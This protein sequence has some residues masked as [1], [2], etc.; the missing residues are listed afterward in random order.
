MRLGAAAALLVLGVVL[1]A[2]QGGA[3]PDL[4][5]H[6]RYL[7]RAA[8][9]EA[10]H[11]APSGQ[12]FAGGRAF[13][14]P[15]GVLY[16]PN[17]TPDATGIAGYTDDAW[18]RMLH[19]GIGRDGQHLYPAMPY[20]SY[21][22]MSRTDALAIKAYLMSLP[23]VHAV[24][25][26]DR[27]RFPFNQRW[28]MFFWNLLYNPDRRFAPD[29]SRSA[30]WN[31]GAYLVEV[32]G[33]CGE[34]HTPRN[35]AM[36]VDN[37]ERL[38]GAMEEGWLAYNLTGDRVHGLGGW[39]DAQLAQYLA[40]GYAEAHGPASGPMAEVV[41]DSLRYLT[42]GD[43]SAIV[44][45]LRSVPAQPDGPEAVVATGRSVVDPNGPG[46]RLFADACE[47]C[48]LPQGTGR[49]S[50][51]AALTGAQSA[52]DPNGTNV[53]AVLTQGSRIDT[54]FGTMF[55][56]EFAGGYTDLEL[57]ALANYVIGQFGYRQ[58][59]IT[60]Q[61]INAARKVVAVP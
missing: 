22:G 30:A 40:T 59:A 53:I 42:P 3:Q 36:A 7:T 61:R 15:F 11:S 50:P 56:H 2:A 9:C 52:G 18:V 23:P 54:A 46:A 24:L 31:H 19:Q 35:F 37:G 41:E 6:G 48:H 51:W 43:I 55:M 21:T 20:P 8:D 10:C 27:L 12:P 5:A 14:L 34:C 16:A 32:L 49:Q 17:I 1:P 25:P 58:G 26:A 57:A 33:H 44:T 4:I 60:P 47:G 28:G 45:Y 39:S 13:R 38:A 29:A